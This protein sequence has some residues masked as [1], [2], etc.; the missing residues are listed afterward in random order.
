MIIKIDLG[1]NIKPKLITTK[2]LKTS[3]EN[4]LLE[5][6]QAEKFTR[7]FPSTDNELASWG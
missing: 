1:R 3:A 5:H 7:T 2:R 6:F 4:H